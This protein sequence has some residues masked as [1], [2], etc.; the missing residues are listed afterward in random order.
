MGIQEHSGTCWDLAVAAAAHRD[1][2]DNVAGNAE[3]HPVDHEIFQ[4]STL[5]ALVEGV[6]D[7]DI[8]Y[9][10][11]MQHGD[12]GLGTFNAL[13]G[14]MTA[15]DGHFFHMFADGSVAPV[16][17]DELTP[18]C[19]VTRFN[20]DAEIDVTESMSRDA[21][22]ALIDGTIPSGNLFYAIRLD[23]VFSNVVTRTVRRQSRPYP[24]LLRA[25]EGQAE[26]R[27]EQVAGTMVGFRSPSYVQGVT[28]AGYHLHFVDSERR[29]GGHV[30]DFQLESGAVL[31]DR[32]IDLH[33][34]L[35]TSDQ[36]LNTAMAAED[37][38]EQIEK[39]E[40][41]IRGD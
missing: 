14:E 2:A 4:V 5:S 30:L 28:V 20:G 9:R 18:F 3:Q 39:A 37:V 22:L 36:F 10:D 16:N 15:F 17:P 25:S 11:V 12:F 24:S 21:L 8:P 13:N 35:P 29:R 7:G 34:E 33:L 23:G 38:G 26:M 40:G 6:L 19:A 1:A 27:F 32:D 41:A 31:I